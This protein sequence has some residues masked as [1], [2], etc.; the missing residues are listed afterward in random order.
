VHPAGIGERDRHRR[1]P[2][3]HEH[4]HQ[5][6]ARD[7][8]GG[9]VVRHLTDAESRRRSQNE[10]ALLADPEHGVFVVA[11]GVGGRAAGE[12]AS[13]LTI[14]V[15]REAAPRLQAAVLRYAERPDWQTRN[16]VL[17]TLDQA[18]Q[19]FAGKLRAA[20]AAGDSQKAQ[21]IYKEGNQ[22]IASRF[23]G[24]TCPGIKAP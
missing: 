19:M 9:D 11:D 22:R 3:A 4:F 12:V 18:C 24:A 14:E 20:Q 6:P 2:V 21:T 15:F 13:A 23:N 16:E 8:F 10:D 1:R 5:S 17:E 7:F